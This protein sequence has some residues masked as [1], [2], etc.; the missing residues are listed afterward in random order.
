MLVKILATFP[1]NK[2]YMLIV[3][4]FHST[5]WADAHNRK[6]TFTEALKVT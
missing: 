6:S 4:I 3:I 2:N 1:N 5:G